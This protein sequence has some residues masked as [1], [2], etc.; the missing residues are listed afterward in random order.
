MSPESIDPELTALA[1]ALGGLRPEPGGLGHDRILFAAGRAAGLRERDRQH[2]RTW[3]AVAAGLALLAT[4]EG[5][6][7][8]RPAPPPRVVERVVVVHQP[9]PA[10]EPV[11]EAI[12]AAIE[13]DPA[14]DAPPT[15]GVL[16]HAARTDR[17]R[18]VDQVLR[19][20]LDGLPPS[21]PT[22]AREPAADDPTRSRLDFPATRLEL[23]DPS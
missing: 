2:G 15:W 14:P 18:L 13:P 20:G 6:L 22:L 8:L 23:G 4:G 7:L 1:A 12:P 17:D 3:R 11:V 5:A 21:P 16:T 10:V 9:A 19:Y